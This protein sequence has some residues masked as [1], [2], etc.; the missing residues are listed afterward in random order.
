M[1]AIGTLAGGIAHDFN[2]ILAAIIGNVDTA[3]H[4]ADA[5]GAG[6]GV[7]H[8]LGQI[9]R[10][11]VRARSLVQQILTF[12]RMQ[13]PVLHAQA[14][15]PVVDEALQ[16]LRATLPPAVQLV[17][18]LPDE[19]VHVRA[20]GTQLQQVVMNLVTNAWHALREGRGRIE[21][22]LAVV[23]TDVDGI[24]GGPHSAHLWVVD[25]GVGMDDATRARIFEPFFTTKPVGRGTG[26]GLAVV[27]GIV[28]SHGGRIVVDSAPGCGSR[29]DL[30]FPLAEA[31][32]EAAPAI[33]AE[34]EAPKGLGEHV[35]CVDDDPAMLL[36]V[37][38]L[39]ERSGYRVS[40]FDRPEDALA[41]VRAAD[42]AIDLVVTDFTMPGMDG[43]ELAT[44]L[45][46]EAPEVPVIITS[47]FITDELREAA[48][49]RGVR[50]LLQKEFTLERLAALVSEVLAERVAR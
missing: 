14:L 34:R 16:I 36:M 29:F 12:S 41:A 33:A 30:R 3:R 22:G 21:V 13:S 24:T 42:G 20:D 2:N 48:H 4:E 46:H 11:A 47:G 50:A 7:A 38:A 40:A 28:S 8:A 19:P 43:I 5:E 31:P 45:A 32:A 18:R 25:D 35:A 44:A 26:L 6:G 39:L 9:H 37:R 15:Q 27:H 49:A 10:A 17:V 1:E 23:P